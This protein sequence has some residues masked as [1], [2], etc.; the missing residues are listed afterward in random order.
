[1]KD[2]IIKETK[3]DNKKVSMQTLYDESAQFEYTKI[4]LPKITTKELI[5]RY[6]K[7]KPI[8]QIEDIH[9]LL[10]E[11]TT[12][13]L[14]HCSY[15]WNQDKDKRNIINKNQ[16]ETIGEFPCYHTYGYHGFFKPSIE[17]VLS[18]FPDELLKEANAFYLYH[19]PETCEDLNKQWDIINAGCQKSNV[20]ALILKK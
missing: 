12:D 14:K 4:I 19:S 16:I 18:Q 13:E 3:L 17:E 1:M 2:R 10:R 8:V 9:Y 15:I 20:K 5:E 7:I 11:F 6:K